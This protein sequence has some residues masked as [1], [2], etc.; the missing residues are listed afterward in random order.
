MINQKDHLMFIQR[1]MLLLETTPP[2]VSLLK[3]LKLVLKKSEL[4]QYMPQ[5]QFIQLL[6]QLGK[7]PVSIKN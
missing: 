6:P 1:K 2:M 7:Q 5:L 3:L 4:N